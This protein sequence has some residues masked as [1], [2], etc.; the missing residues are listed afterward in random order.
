M[1]QTT[2]RRQQE[3]WAEWQADPRTA[4]FRRFLRA[5]QEA[6]KAE[7]T[8]YS[9]DQGKADPLVLTDLR[10]RARLLDELAD[11]SMEAVEEFEAHAEHKRD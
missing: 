8:T 3:A 1:D 9:W 4:R 6:L 2:R 10:A 11:L 5:Y 7:W